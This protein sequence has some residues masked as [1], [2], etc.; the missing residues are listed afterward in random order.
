M[1]DERRLRSR[2]LP[3]R[4]IVTYVYE[5]ILVIVHLEFEKEVL[6]CLCH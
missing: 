4:S 1:V 6:L 5:G 2:N 3:F